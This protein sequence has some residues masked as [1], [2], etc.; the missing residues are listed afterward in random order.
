[1][2]RRG[3]RADEKMPAPTA[4]ATPMMAVPPFQIAFELVTLLAGFGD[5]LLD[6]FG[7][8]RC[9]IRDTL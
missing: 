6:G 9:S 8:N 1:M 5:G 3:L 4:T 7:T 2:E